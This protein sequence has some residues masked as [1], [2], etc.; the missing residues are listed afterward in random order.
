MIYLWETRQNPHHRMQRG[1]GTS[2][3]NVEEAE[4]EEE[5]AE[6]AGSHVGISYK[7]VILDH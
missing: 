5:D 2:L 1:D 7:F 4:S 6:E 3:R